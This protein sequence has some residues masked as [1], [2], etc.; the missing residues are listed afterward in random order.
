MLPFKLHHLHVAGKHY[1]LLPKLNSIQMKL[2]V[3]RF[4]RR[5]FTISLSYLL[6][7]RSRNGSIHVSP[8]GFCWS[9]F[10]PED[11]V[12]PAIPELLSCQRK[13]VPMGALET[14]YFQGEHSGSRQFARL[15]TRMESG[16]RWDYLR[17]SGECGLTP[18]ERLVALAVFNGA[19]K[20][21]VLTDYVPGE[22]AP[23]IC[24]RRRYFE[25]TLDSRTAASTLRAVGEGAYRNS[26]L[27][28]DGAI[29]SGRTPSVSDLR[30]VF[31]KLD[32]WC[33]FVP[34]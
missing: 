2:L 11:V 25:A 19:E 29:D 17:A 23:L 22:P 32:E 10:D 20:C 18:D 14:L 24:G 9:S 5:S 21:R 30:N 15:L 13:A 34:N 7:A 4:E 28:R 26:Y 16:T 8:A 12:T 1:L 33:F 27:P 3:E 6:S 31:E